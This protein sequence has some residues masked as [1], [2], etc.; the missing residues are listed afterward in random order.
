M[1]SSGTS[2][3]GLYCM[4]KSAMEALFLNLAVDYG[5][6]NVL[7]NVLRPG[8][9]RTERTKR[10]WRRPSY[11]E[12]ANRMIPQGKLGEPAQIAEVALYR[13][14]AVAGFQREIV[15]ELLQQEPAID[16]IGTCGHALE[17]AGPRR[18]SSPAAARR[19]TSAGP[20]ARAAHRR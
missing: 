19:D 6:H 5:R 7:A 11:Q 15:L 16:L 9:V 4:T 20:R 3:H 14:P 17:P 18:R 1:V 2:R 10:F 12:K 8:I 13:V